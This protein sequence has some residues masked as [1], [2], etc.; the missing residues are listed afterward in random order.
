MIGDGECEMRHLIV[1]DSQ[2][3]GVAD[4]QSKGG[5]IGAGQPS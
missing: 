5:D 1:A 4:G 2:E 3:Q